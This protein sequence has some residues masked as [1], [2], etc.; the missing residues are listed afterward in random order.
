MNKAFDSSIFNPIKGEFLVP[1]YYKHFSCKGAN[2][3]NTCCSGWSVKISMKEYFFL[4]GLACKKD[5]REK[6]DVALRPLNNRNESNYAE[7]TFDHNNKCKLLSKDG[8][9]F[10]HKHYG[11]QVLSSVCRY[12]PRGARINYR[13]EA[14]T[15]NAC[16]RTLELLFEDTNPIIYE[17][18]NLTFNLTLSRVVNEQDIFLYAPVRNKC[19]D[20]I[21]DR[22]Y[23]LSKRIMKIGKLLMGLDKQH[24][25]T[26]IDLSVIDYESDT[27][28]TYENA[29]I[30]CDWFIEHTGTF[31]EYF[32]LIKQL[33]CKQDVGSLLKSKTEEFNIAFPEHEIYFEKA[34]TNN[35]YYK[36]F[37]FQDYTNNFTDEFIALSGKYFI[38]RYICVNILNINSKQEDFIDLLSRLFRV[39]AHTGFEKNIMILFKK[40]G[41]NEF[42]TLGKLLLI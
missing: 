42:D 1:N 4:H 30:I 9:C 39:I 34:L 11:E 15:S 32:D 31:S 20:V 40:L 24:D 12:F 36:Q 23:R 6:L 8:L 14:S 7:I 38:L 2:C 13:W 16:E 17:I 5:L 18:N 22:R 35:I 19:I 25:I 41:L 28:Y 3:R 26:E 21:Q 33:Y 29:Q 27:L 37:P 10:L